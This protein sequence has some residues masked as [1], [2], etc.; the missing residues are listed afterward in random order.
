MTRKTA[1]PETSTALLPQQAAGM[2]VR[3]CAAY[4]IG[5]WA[6]HEILTAYGI[7]PHPSFQYLSI[8]IGVAVYLVWHGYAHYCKLMGILQHIMTKWQHSPYATSSGALM[9]GGS[10]LALLNELSRLTDHAIETHRLHMHLRMQLSANQNTLSHYQSLTTLHGDMRSLFARIADYTQM[11]EETI[12]RRAS[13]SSLHEVFDELS[14]QS[15]HLQLFIAA[16]ER[17]QKPAIRTGW[18]E[19]TD[20]TH[21]LSRVLV[22]LAASL[23]R[24]AMQLSSLAWNERV[25]AK[26]AA[27]D[28]ELIIWLMLLGTVRYA[29]EEST[30]VLSCEPATDGSHTIITC[31]VSE[32]A[33]AAMSAHERAAFMH[34]KQK[35]KSA[36]MFAH[37]LAESTSLML[38][39]QL[40]GRANG[41]LSVHA[42]S[43]TSCLIELTLPC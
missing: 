15:F 42:R 20:P 27:N 37:T 3:I 34:E 39:R 9:H 22:P 6:T 5:L 2:G 21:T 41:A 36:H 13:I 18:V 14:E 12:A 35:Y 17:L 8:G 1:L 25:R 38:A 23:D 7:T 31:L 33:P 28:L 43:Q 10:P 40:A 29:E 26:I 11:L 4:V 30:L 19:I 32:L 16:F 24:R